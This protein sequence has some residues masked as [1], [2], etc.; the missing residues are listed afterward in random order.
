MNP[1]FIIDTVQ[2]MAETAPD[3]FKAT[4]QDFTHRYGKL[5][6]APS[7]ESII[8]THSQRLVSQLSR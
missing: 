5:P 1:K 4:L 6:I 3:L 7:I 8:K 2:E